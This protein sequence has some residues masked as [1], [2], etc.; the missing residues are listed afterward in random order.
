MNYKNPESKDHCK[1]EN[2]RTEVLLKCGTA[3][4]VILTVLSVGT[5]L[6]PTILHLVLLL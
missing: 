2:K 1:V 4:S 5:I 6:A 3:G